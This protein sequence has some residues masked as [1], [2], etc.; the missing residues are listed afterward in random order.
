MGDIYRYA[1]LTLSAASATNSADGL[2]MPRDPDATAVCRIAAADG[3]MSLV[4]PQPGIGLDFVRTRG[5]T[6][7]EL[8]LPPRLVHYTFSKFG[9]DRMMV[10]ECQAGKVQE[11]GEKVW[12]DQTKRLLLELDDRFGTEGLDSEGL[13]TLNKPPIVYTPPTLAELLGRD[14]VE[15]GIKEQ[16]QYHAIWRKAV[17]ELSY[18]QLTQIADRLPALSGIT[19]LLQKKMVQAGIKST[20]VA[21]LWTGEELMHQLMWTAPVPPRG[22]MIKRAS[23][24]GM[25]ALGVAPSWSWASAGGIVRW[26]ECHLLQSGPPTPAS[27]EQDDDDGTLPGIPD[28]HPFPAELVDFHVTPENDHNPLGRVQPGGFLRIRGKMREARVRSWTLRPELP[29]RVA[30]QIPVI[31]K[32]NEAPQHAFETYDDLTERD[33]NRVWEV[34]DLILAKK[35]DS[36][37][38]ASATGLADRESAESQLTLIFQETLAPFAEVER[39]LQGLVGQ[40]AV[41]PT[42]DDEE[43]LER[44]LRLFNSVKAQIPQFYEHAKRRDIESALWNWEVYVNRVFTAVDLLYPYLYLQSLMVDKT[45]DAITSAPKFTYT[46]VSCSM[47]VIFSILANLNN[48]KD[49]AKER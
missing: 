42:V 14:V 26:C 22:A 10:W 41:H 36:S 9:G 5:W 18:R 45:I 49:P 33:A 16:P 11:D 39:T 43:K 25:R 13:I 37:S 30:V 29:D 7:Q 47:G 31:L 17:I 8:L 20:F 3:E 12:R 40:L 23:K 35:V 28:R 6:L 27:W 32:S 46:E 21:G 44:C 48:I 2:L 24:P 15:T 38:V 34:I 19:A 4:Y 1:V